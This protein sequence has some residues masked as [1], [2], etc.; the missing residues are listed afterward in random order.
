MK[1]SLERR[2]GIKEAR[3]A[4]KRITGGLSG[5]SSQ[6]RAQRRAKESK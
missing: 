5:N 4:Q 2:K 1:R 6:R 3:R